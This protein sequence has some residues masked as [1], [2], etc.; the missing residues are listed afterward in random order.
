MM[1]TMSSLMFPT[2]WYD[3]A[4]AIAAPARRRNPI[5]RIAAAGALRYGPQED[6]APEDSELATNESVVLTET[7]WAVAADGLTGAKVIVEHLEPWEV[8]A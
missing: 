3:G 1:F 7:A 5:N 4:C 2:G 6:P 8:A